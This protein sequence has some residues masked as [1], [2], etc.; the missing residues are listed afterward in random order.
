MATGALYGAIGLKRRA[1]PWASGIA[2]G[3]AVWAAS[4][5]GWIPGLGILAA[6]SEHPPRRNG[7]MIFA[8]VVWGT[9]LGLATDGLHESRSAFARE[10]D[11]G[12]PKRRHPK[13]RPDDRIPLR[14]HSAVS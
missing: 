10:V 12:A 4:Y 5:L 3:L 1:Q 9:V 6:A 7:V 8:H 13:D 14:A 11:A 2:F